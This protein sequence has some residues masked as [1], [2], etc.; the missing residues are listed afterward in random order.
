MSDS[1][2]A[3]TPS[4]PRTR[5]RSLFG[6]KPTRD[7][8]LPGKDVPLPPVPA[9][10]GASTANRAGGPSTETPPHSHREPSGTLDKAQRP[11]HRRTASSII[12][13]NSNAASKTPAKQ[14]KGSV[15][16]S[17][18]HAGPGEPS[19]PS[20]PSTS[21][22][23]A[24]NLVATYPQ[25][26]HTAPAPVYAT[27]NRSATVGSASPATTPTQPTRPADLTPPSSSGRPR[28]N[29]WR[30]VRPATGAD[31]YTSHVDSPAANRNDEEEEVCD[32]QRPRSSRG[33]RGARASMLA[34]FKDT[35]RRSESPPDS[36]SE[37]RS[38]S[39]AQRKSLFPRASTPRGG[40]AE[41]AER[42]DQTGGLLKRMSS[43]NLMSASRE[44]LRDPKPSMN[45]SR[46][47]L[48]SSAGLSQ[49]GSSNASVVRRAS[50][51]T[52]R[53]KGAWL[54]QRQRAEMRATAGE[55]TSADESCSGSVTASNMLSP[56]AGDGEEDQSLA[57]PKRLSG[58]LLNMLGNDS[59]PSSSP[60]HS[61][62]RASPS[63][64]PSN[65][66]LAS[67][68]CPPSSHQ[69]S[70]QS[71]GF[72]SNFSSTARAR[73]AAAAGVAVATTGFDRALRYMGEADTEGEIWLLGVRHGMPPTPSSASSD[74]PPVIRV[75]DA[76][77]QASATT[78]PL[79][80]SSRAAASANPRTPRP[81]IPSSIKKRGKSGLDRGSAGSLATED[82]PR[83]PRR[84]RENSVPDSL[85]S[86]RSDD[87]A[88]SRI[89][90]DSGAEAGSV[91]SPVS[92]NSEG[93][94]SP[95]WQADFTSDFTSKIWCTYRNHFTPIARDGA[96]ADVET[97][98]GDNESQNTT[99]TS[100]LSTPLPSGQ[101]HSPYRK[102]SAQ[103]IPQSSLKRGA[104]LASTM[105]AD[106]IQP[107][108]SLSAALGVASPQA[109]SAP[110]SS[111]ASL[112]EK[113]GLPNLWG[114]ATAAVQATGLAGRS[115]LTT[116]A[117]WGCMLR[118]GQ[119]LLANALIEA[120]LGRDWRRTPQPAPCQQAP[121][122]GS[123]GLQRWE[124]D[125][126]RFAKYV[127]IVSWFLDDPSASCPFGIHRM[128]REG[129]RLGKEVG[130]WFGPSTAAGAIRRL[131]DEFPHAGIG[132]S[133]ATDGVVYLNDVRAAASRSNTKRDASKPQQRHSSRDGR[134][135]VSD[136]TRAVLILVNV[137][138][139]LDGVHPMYHDSIQ[140]LFTFPQSVGIAGGR[141]SSSY[142]FVGYQGNNLLYLDPHNVRPAVALRTP[143]QAW[144]ASDAKM[145]DGSAPT[146]AKDE[147]KTLDSARDEWWSHAYTDA[148]LSTFHCDRVRRM[149]FR[150]LDPS[151]LLG[152]LVTDESSLTDL[153]SRI[154]S[155]ARPI[156]SIQ[157]EM[158]RWMREGS[159]GNV[160]GM[161]ESEEENEIVGS[162]PGD[163]PSLESFSESSLAE[164]S[165]AKDQTDADALSSEKETS[166]EFVS[167][168]TL[169]DIRRNGPRTSLGLD[170]A[171]P[172]ISAA[173]AIGSVPLPPATLDSERT[174]A[175]RPSAVSMSSAEASET[176][177][178][179]R[180]CEPRGDSSTLHA[181][182]ADLRSR[183]LSTASDL[184]A[185]NDDGT[186]RSVGLTSARKGRLEPSHSDSGRQLH[187]SDSQTV[188]AL[189]QHAETSPSP[190]RKSSRR[191]T[192]SADAMPVVPF[193]IMSDSSDGVRSPQ[194]TT[195]GQE[196]DNGKI[197]GSTA[198]REQVHH[199]VQ[200]ALGRGVADS[201]PSIAVSPPS[202]QARRAKATPI[203][204]APSRTSGPQ[205]GALAFPRAGTSPHN[206]GDRA[207]AAE[208]S[209]SWEEV[210]FDPAVASSPSLT[211]SSCMASKWDERRASSWT[212]VEDG[213]E[214]EAAPR[215]LP[216]E[217]LAD[218]SEGS[219]PAQSDEPSAAQRRGPGSGFD[220]IASNAV[221][222]DDD[223]WSLTFGPADT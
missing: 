33:W 159:G 181:A 16:E 140:R 193:P 98:R 53:T 87:T 62:A 17:S 7:K 2:N 90:R 99:S 129:K 31:G 176:P 75:Q 70:K 143:P 171:G 39:P 116:D 211:S 183:H 182:D 72:L 56:S 126:A 8:G 162:D 58:W 97:H 218:S 82:S 210:S 88:A 152:F 215:G 27:R 180:M 108:L 178:T 130:E 91:S 114:R 102:T 163:D 77:P 142:Y 214:L 96:I 175:G 10:A 32:D 179:A 74:L 4:A 103:P 73:A 93:L 189:E 121:E 195:N 198:E 92:Q 184:T 57:L 212:K 64:R 207:A 132:I 22:S 209:T 161:D 128:A 3:T 101:G 43:R 109:V 95:G 157:S 85:S 190:E 110:S 149:P 150:S 177:L 45:A 221:T 186:N 165:E 141:P 28:S 154:K 113:M 127:E 208:C 156:F 222:A 55:A 219:S 199:F 65:P 9:N 61:E 25:A 11:S 153:S 120:H 145:R 24:S 136:W 19:T 21:A 124:F 47:S 66:S 133:V 220:S 202:E 206:A 119:S 29:T 134:S 40:S 81:A 148:E 213:S 118:T 169:L 46:E 6:A 151:M 42:Q 26:P 35:T 80:S 15:K 51:T 12:R 60:S 54:P 49:G 94:V 200:P 135:S 69:K 197:F 36:V 122:Q 158:P 23:Q 166:A 104:E 83:S 187:T 131:A 170:L 50:S 173:E 155:L 188:S 117:G 13:L 194:I 164:E 115:G 41:S 34:A 44:S 67:G 123:A 112:S 160:G 84:T 76:S 216:T 138:L 146:V 125:R 137:R 37:R 52:D 107:T 201:Q 86:T 38:A 203:D 63:R 167:Q 89:T 106:T 20:R 30:G 105:V 192:L 204:H 71:P 1:V 217:I 196:S 48:A 111:G 100:G 223:D 139:G 144:E 168:A 18:R 172:D 205:N 174:P 79:A 191:P 185:R 147:R 68:A 5:R 78:T 14:M 59:S